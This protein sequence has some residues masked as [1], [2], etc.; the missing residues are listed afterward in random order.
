MQNSDFAPEAGDLIEIQTYTMP[1]DQPDHNQR[2]VAV[3]VPTCNPGLQWQGFV[4]AL[5]GQTLRPLTCVMVDSQSSDGAVHIARDAGW[6]VQSIPRASF[7][8][9]ATRQMAIDQLAGQV[10]IVVF[11]TQDAILAEPTALEQLLV[12]FDEGTVAAAY[13]RQLPHANATP[14]AAHARWFNYPASDHTRRWTD[15]P[16]FGI[17]TCFL[18]NAFAAYR[19]SALREVGGFAPDVILGEDMHLAARL[20]QAGHTIAYRAQATVF[21]SHNYTLLEEFRRYFDTGVFHA[22]QAWLIRD[23]GGAGPDGLRFVRSEMAYLLRH[24]PW[25]LPESACRTLLKALAYRLG[26]LSARLPRRVCLGL[27]MHKGYWA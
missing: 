9:G 20:L 21:H 3:L 1:V 16:R 5:Q 8:H 26:R 6:T 23:F 7:N 25:R 13:G 11:L 24:A 4:Q 17:K 12:A 27:S 22:H 10:D 15:V 2:R 18:S 19:V 14:L